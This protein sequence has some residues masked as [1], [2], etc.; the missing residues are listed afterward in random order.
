MSVSYVSDWSA[1]LVT[2]SCVCQL[3]RCLSA[4]SVSW[5]GD[6]QLCL[7]AVSIMSMGVST[8]VH[9]YHSVSDLE[10]LLSVLIIS[11]Q[12]AATKTLQFVT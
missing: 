2:I 7:S 8:L 6:C 4:M 3:C 12:F 11:V 1:G 5:V 9:V 10:T